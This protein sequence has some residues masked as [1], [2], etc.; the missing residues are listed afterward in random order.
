MAQRRRV[1]V[2]G[3]YRRD[4]TWVNSYTQ[5]RR[6]A[7]PDTSR[8]R[9]PTPPRARTRDQ[10]P[11]PRAP[12]K[13]ERRRPERIPQRVIDA[14]TNVLTQGWSKAVANQL[15]TAL[16]G[17][18]RPKKIRRI[19]CRPIADIADGME[20]VKSEAHDAVGALATVSGVKVLGLTTLE[21]KVA[22]AVARKIPIPGEESIS[23]AVQK[24][25]II[26]VWICLMNGRINVITSCPCFRALA[27]EKSKEEIQKILETKLNELSK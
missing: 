18:I 15:N 7:A 26:G 14:A 25:R 13:P 22:G 10:I 4:G 1:S 6:T 19:S 16:W 21:G 17:V 11:A 27:N 20:Q 24:L 9:H 2:N 5:K 3:Y 23:L 8:A 12:T